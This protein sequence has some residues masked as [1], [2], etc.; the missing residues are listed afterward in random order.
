MSSR[1]RRSNIVVLLVVA[2]GQHIL[3]IDFLNRY[4]ICMKDGVRGIV[5]H[6]IPTANSSHVH[7]VVVV[8][9][10]VVFLFGYP[11]ARWFRE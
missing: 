11:Y 3:R 10:Y 4:T 1:S 6:I 2:V 5:V 9:H 7:L 8:H